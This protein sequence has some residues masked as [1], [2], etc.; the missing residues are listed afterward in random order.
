MVIMYPDLYSEAE[1]EE[2][3]EFRELAQTDPVHL[4]QLIMVTGYDALC[5]LAKQIA[6]EQEAADDAAEAQ[7]EIDRYIPER[8]A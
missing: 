6:A 8:D 5:T 1:I 3:A 2:D 4:R 7:W